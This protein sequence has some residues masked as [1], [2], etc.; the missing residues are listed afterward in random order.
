MAI[1]AWLE[2]ETE[3]SQEQT[4][5]ELVFDQLLTSSE[6]KGATDLK[7][8]VEIAENLH[9]HDL[10]TFKQA[11]NMAL[12]A[13]RIDNEIEKARK[14]IVR[15]HLDFQ[16]AVKTYADGIRLSLEKIEK[17][18]TTKLEAFDKL[19]NVKVE[20]G[21]MSPKS[22]W[23]YTIENKELLPA[24]FLSP[25]EKKIKDAIDAGVRHIEGV[26]IYE[27]VKPLYRIK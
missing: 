17:T 19:A 1:G 13:R 18:L 3:K 21:S 24:Q 10:D 12:Q 11:L 25:D 22:S 27:E 16:K 4:S 20:S 2:E 7:G 26:R 5:M 23:A 6:L 15:P 9:I 8:M 14:E